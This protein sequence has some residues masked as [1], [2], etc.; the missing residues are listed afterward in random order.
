M[1]AEMTSSLPHADDDAVLVARS[2]AGDP[3]AF[4]DLVVRH[5][6]RVVACA[7]AVLRNEADAADVAQEVFIRLHRHLAQVDP[8]RPLA[9]YLLR[10]T[11]NRAR[12]V[13]RQRRRHDEVGDDLLAAH[14]DRRPDPGESLMASELARRVRALVAELPLS[15]RE[16]CSLF[17]LSECSCAEVASILGMS[18]S[19]VKVALHRARKRLLSI[20]NQTEA[21]HGES[22]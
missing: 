17:Y 12:D 18:E 8:R 21:A 7:R 11:V 13:L 5:Q 6:G 10:I 22:F 2:R 16:V 14:P 1:A 20:L 15:M 4:R 19:A 9:P 3:A